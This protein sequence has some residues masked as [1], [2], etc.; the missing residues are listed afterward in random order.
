MYSWEAKAGAH[1]ELD[2]EARRTAKHR[3]GM[4]QQHRALR[5]ALAAFREHK[6]VWT[7]EHPWE[8]ELGTSFQQKTSV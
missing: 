2:E 3:E 5:L 7:E 6:G 4:I 8:R 1:T